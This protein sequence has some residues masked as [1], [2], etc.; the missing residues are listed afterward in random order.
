MGDGGFRVLV[1]RALALATE[2][3]PSFR[4]VRVNAN[5]T[6]EALTG[7]GAQQ[8]PPQLAEGCVVL[9]AQL[10]G[11]LVSFIGANLTVG[12]VREVWPEMSLNNSEF[13]K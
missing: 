9:L 6:L 4:A 7:S 5:G 2:E 8:D 10:L 13:G 11:L 1:T 12:L 3:V